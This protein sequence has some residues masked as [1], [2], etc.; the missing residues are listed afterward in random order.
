MMIA[1]AR[2]TVRV[3]FAKAIVIVCDASLLCLFVSML[4]ERRNLKGRKLR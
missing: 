2:V 4:F 3:R 1:I